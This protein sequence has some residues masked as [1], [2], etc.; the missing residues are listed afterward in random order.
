[1]NG[2]LH[3][4]NSNSILPLQLNNYSQHQQGYNSDHCT[5][6]LRWKTKINC[7]VQL[8]SGSF[9]QVQVKFY[10]NKSKIKN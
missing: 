1:M 3:Q 7:D 9:T 2:H 10:L 8:L 4:F 5:H 6:T